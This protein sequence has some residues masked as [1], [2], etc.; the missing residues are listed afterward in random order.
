[1]NV[2]S[3]RLVVGLGFIGSALTEDFLKIGYDT[4]VLSRSTP[5]ESQFENASSIRQVVGDAADSQLMKDAIEDVDQVYWCVGGRL[6]SESEED[7][8]GSIMDRCRP[9]LAALK[10]M[11]QLDKPPH[12]FLFSSGGTIYGENLD[13]PFSEDSLTSPTTA[14]GIANLCSELLARQYAA[15]HSFRLTIFRCANVYGRFQQPGRSQGLIATA[16]E[17]GKNGRPVTVFGD[18]DSIRDYIHIDDLVQI[19]E[20]VSD[21]A[22]PPSVLNVCSGVGT[23]VN[24]VLAAVEKSMGIRLNVKIAE[25]RSSDLRSVV[26]DST[27]V[28][29]LTGIKT[30]SL[31]D[32][33]LRTVSGC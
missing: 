7:V 3:K 12:L 5:R 20:R 16:I 9:L 32:G 15:R 30:I 26:L 17:S 31:C 14:Y 24:E 28:H 19:V 29:T 23:T 4:R 27:L 33:I 2:E 13:V 25:S 6:P 22:S 11:E 1:V 10:A 8:L 21:L 18:G